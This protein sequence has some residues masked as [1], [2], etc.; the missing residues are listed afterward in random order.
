[1]IATQLVD[2]SDL[3]ATRRAR[4]FGLF[5]R[6]HVQARSPLATSVFK[7]HAHNLASFQA[8]LP[9]DWPQDRLE[10]PQEGLEALRNPDYF[11][12]AKNEGQAW[13]KHIVHEYQQAPTFT[14]QYETAFNL[15]EHTFLKGGLHCPIF[16]PPQSARMFSPCEIARLHAL[17]HTL[18]LPGDLLT[19]WQIL[20]NGV[21]R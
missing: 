16:C 13:M 8:V 17:P 12:Y 6:T 15:P 21:L 18:V 11:K 9:P 14:H 10:I 20:G 7:R 19:C 5:V 1:M 4:W 3:T 2:L